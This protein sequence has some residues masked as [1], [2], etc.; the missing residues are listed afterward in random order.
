MQHDMTLHPSRASFHKGTKAARWHIIRQ[1]ITNCFHS[2]ISQII[3][4]DIAMLF[5]ISDQSS[6]YQTH[7]AYPSSRRLKTLANRAASGLACTVGE[8]TFMIAPIGRLQ[9]LE[10]NIRNLRCF[11]TLKIRLQNFLG[12]PPFWQAML[13]YSK[14]G[15]LFVKQHTPKA[16]YLLRSP[17][18]CLA[19]PPG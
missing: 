17:S 19:Q 2:I 18:Y 15:A 5:E 14:M 11:L 16:T 6:A 9:P 13:R 7:N 12:K 10:W 3:L 4:R 1:N 8:T